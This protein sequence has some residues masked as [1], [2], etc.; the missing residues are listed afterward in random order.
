MCAQCVM[1]TSD[2]DIT[3]DRE[4]VCNH[5]HSYYAVVQSPARIKKRTPE[6]LD[7]VLKT[8]KETGKGKEYDC[9]IGVSGGTDSTF[10]AYEVKR[11]GLRPLAVHFDN[12]WD[13]ELAVSN[14]EKVL[15]KLDIA[16]YT[17]VMDWEEFRDLQLSFL[18]ASTPDSEIPTDHA[19]TATLYKMA[20]KY[21]V[22]YIISGGNDQTEGIMPRLWSHGHGDWQY[23]KSVQKEF[24]TIKL[25]K[26]PHYSMIDLFRFTL[27]KKINIVYLLN[28]IPYDKNKIGTKLE[29][30]LGWRNYG[31]KHYESIYTRFFQ[32]YILPEKFGIDKRRAHLSS[33]INAGIITRDT[34]LT[35]LE[36]PIYPPELLREDKEFFLKKMGL[37]NQ[38]FEVIMTRPQKTFDDYPSYE[39]NSL[40]QF[41]IKAL[42]VLRGISTK[43]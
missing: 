29:Q 42:R 32:G 25:K 35:E 38:D 16:L 27:I 13:S 26:F 10:V 1:D 20:E 11:R 4:G 12:G 34:A 5:C 9:I 18:R 37:S 28:F 30:E 24:G 8:I 17:Y 40:V 6:K 15:K 36:Q 2:P 3:F 14:I 19:I 21:N 39:K 22:P 23:I 43:T 41:S 7:S 33:M 31:G